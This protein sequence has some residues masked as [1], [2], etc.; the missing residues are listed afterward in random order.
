MEPAKYDLKCKA[1]TTFRKSFKFRDRLDNSLDFTGYSARMHVRSSIEATEVLVSLH[2]DYVTDP[3]AEGAYGTITIDEANGSID[4]FIADDVTSDF[5]AAGYVYDIELVSAG[6]I[7]DSPLYG[8]FKV[9]A[10]VTR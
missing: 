5:A 6:G 10:E 8:K 2:S 1:G 4:L 7:V 9:T 3:P